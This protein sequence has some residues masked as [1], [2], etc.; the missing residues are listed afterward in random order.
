MR[1]LAPR[2]SGV[3]ISLNSVIWEELTRAVISQKYS[4]AWKKASGLGVPTSARRVFHLHNFIRWAGAI[5][6]KKPWKSSLQLLIFQDLQ[7]I[8]P[9]IAKLESQKWHRRA[10]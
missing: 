4:R 1:R 8:H 9:M 6:S 3:M 7:P 10:I 5:C 2:F